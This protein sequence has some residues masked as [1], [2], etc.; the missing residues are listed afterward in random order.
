MDDVETWL[1]GCEE[2]REEAQAEI[3]DLRAKLEAAEQERDQAWT[4]A[5]EYGQ[6]AHHWQDVYRTVKRRADAAEWRIEQARWHARAM[7]STFGVTWVNALKELRLVLD[8]TAQPANAEE[9]SELHDW[10]RP[11]GRW[12]CVRCGVEKDGWARPTASGCPAN[13]EAGPA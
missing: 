11:R 2:G 10:K 1:E 12:H 4:E 3:A 6:D 7:D 9:K 8:Q 5:E 13:A